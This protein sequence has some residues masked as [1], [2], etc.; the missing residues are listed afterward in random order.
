MKLQTLTARA[1]RLESAASRAR[2]AADKEAYKRMIAA[3]RRRALGPKNKSDFMR[4]TI[5]DR[6]RE[7]ENN[8]AKA[9]VR[10]VHSRLQAET[11]HKSPSRDLRE[12]SRWGSTGLVLALPLREITHSH[13][14]NSVRSSMSSHRS[15]ENHGQETTSTSRKVNKTR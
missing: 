2:L 4:Q 14:S 15:S 12:P 1:T 13:R 7:R 10:S 11:T 6:E 9:K 5:R 3:K 8:R